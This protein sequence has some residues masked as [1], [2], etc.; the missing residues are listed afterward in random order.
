MKRTLLFITI[1]MLCFS[2]QTKAFVKVI[3]GKVT[4]ADSGDGIPGVSVYVKGSTK[5]TITDLNGLYNIEAYSGAI[6]VFQ[7]V[8]LKTKE[9]LVEHQ[10]I[11]NVALHQDVKEL[12]EVVTTRS[13]RKGR[14]QNKALRGRVAGIQTNKSKRRKKGYTPPPPPEDYLNESYDDINESGFLKPSKKPLST[15]SIDVDKA[16]YS[17]VRRFIN[18]GQK[19]PKDAVR[20]EEII[21]Y[22]NYDYPQPE[23]KHPFAIQTE[24]SQSPWKEENLLLHIGIQGKKIPTEN[25]PPSNLVFLIDVSGSMGDVNK[26]P[27]LK[28][29][30]KMLVKELRPQDQVA[31]VVYAG[32]A[33]QVLPSTSGKK[34]E[35][36]L[37]ALDNLE[38]GGSTAG[39]AGIRLAYQI[40]QNNF[41][42]GGNNRVILA[43]DGDF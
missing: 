27:L 14:K 24:L 41:K 16:A 43:T 38:A 3:Y 18:N 30:F 34:K 37:E 13:K 20:I 2:F 33:G 21:N 23:G 17:N 11:I 12:K 35:K 39:G 10:T 1:I 7:S 22:F 25:L 36:I 29:A 15:F 40:A 4:S 19:P 9:V 31:I 6:L 5:G 8:G 42:K 26:L 28:S 32:A